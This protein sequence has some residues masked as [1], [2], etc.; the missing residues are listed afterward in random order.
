MFKL[1]KYINLLKSILRNLSKKRQKLIINQLIIL[2][3][4]A[5]LE[6]SL[7][8]AT[9][10]FLN[11]LSFS[12]DN[13]E[14]FIVTFLYS[15]LVLI[16]CFARV[17]NL[18]KLNY[19]S[20]ALG[21]TLS[22]KA[23]E[24]MLYQSYEEHIQKKSNKV[25]NNLVNNTAVTVRVITSYLNLI[26]SSFILILIAFL[27]LYKYPIIT[28]ILIIILS[29]SYLFISNSSKNLILKNSK[30][31]AKEN[32]NLI[33]IIQE[34]FG[35]Y[36]DTL[37]NRSQKNFIK[38]LNFIDSKLRIALSTNLYL[39]TYPRYINES[40]IILLMI[41]LSI[42][43]FLNPLSNSDLVF[44]KL[45]IFAIAGLKLLPGIQMIYSSWAMINTYYDSTKELINIIE[46]KR[47]EEFSSTNFSSSF[48]KKKSFI[49]EL[50]KV[51]YKYPKKENYAVNSINLKMKQGE[52]IGIKGDSGAGKSTLLDL[53]MGL[54]TP[55][56]GEIYFNKLS[57]FK[58][59]TNII[60]YRKIISHVPQNPYINYGNIIENITLN[61]DNLNV[62]QKNLELA[63]KISSF[64]EILGKDLKL[65]SYL[66][67]RGQLLS[68]GQRQ[69]LS[70]ARSIYRM[71]RILF[72]DEFTSA[73]DSKVEE[74]ILNNLSENLSDMLIV[75]I[76]HRYRPLEICN[77]VISIKKGEIVI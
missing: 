18:W 30:I 49:V 42:Y 60:N 69:R 39:T 65:D 27:L 55:S 58:N 19:T 74:K 24:T 14:F 10:L 75:I 6:L 32:N 40:I 3:I 5:L 7:V 46:K 76:S 4:S 36:R 47:P 16:S 70:I 43:L 71:P 54:L 25:I 68:G 41:F 2:S 1:F 57:I 77:R 64:D 61:K 38:D 72:L 59:R 20:S 45:S 34:G 22:V 28:L 31:I 44:S 29:T 63:L 50:K 17:Y 35:S 13:K 51:S 11:N 37:I 8:A 21:T 66:G 56:K 12:S 62:N 53:M 48:S 23:F 67:E 9:P 52:I 73:L 26:S 33:K 15:S